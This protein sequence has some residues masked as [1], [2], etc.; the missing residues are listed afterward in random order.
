MQN[1]GGS[2]L[3]RTAV[4]NFSVGFFFDY[5]GAKIRVEITLQTLLTR[6]VEV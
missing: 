1:D 2:L 6:Q 5:R 4:L 3:M